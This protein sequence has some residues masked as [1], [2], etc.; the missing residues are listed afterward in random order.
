MRS[1]Y[2][3]YVRLDTIKFLF[4]GMHIAQND[5]LRVLSWGNSKALK[6]NILTGY[7]RR[8][9]RFHVLFARN[10]RSVKQSARFLNDRNL[11]TT[12]IDRSMTVRLSDK[13]SDKI[14]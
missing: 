13:I 7:Y 14:C 3:D 8:N 11:C 6:N 1:G 12:A 2:S 10:N 9:W 5:K 4:I